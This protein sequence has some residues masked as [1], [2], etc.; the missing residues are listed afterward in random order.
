MS[1]IYNTQEDIATKIKS[2]LQSICQDIRKTQLNIIPYILIGMF[3]SESVVAHDIAKQLKGAF[4]LVQQP[5]VVKRIRR[6]FKNKLFDGYAF[7][8]KIIRYVIANYKKK[9]SDR[10][11]HVIFDHMFSHDNYTVFMIT[12]RIGKQGIPLWF[13][14]FEGNDCPDAFDENLLK[15]GITYVSELFGPG[16]DL[17]FLADRWFNSISLMQHIASLGHTFNLRLKKSLKVLVYDKK[18]GHNIWKTV[19]EL[20]SYQFHSNWYHDV[21]LSEYEYKVNIAISKR[22]GVAEPWII[23]TNG[24]AKQAIKDYSYRFGAIESVFKNQKSNG[25]YLENTVTA[26]LK[27]FESM[28]CIASVGVL[29]LTIF[30]ADFTKNTKLYKNVKIETHK[31]KGST[32]VR[33][34]SLFN[35]GLTLFHMAFNSLRYIHLPIRFILYDI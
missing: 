25:F 3:L 6:F 34:M 20:Q 12:M 5:S 16:Y 8:N 32:K 19:G 24:D 35:T 21:I 10:R 14:C 29:L 27:Y 28:Y 33:I 13:R 23:V 4:S 7:Y 30:G 22:E 2:I 26:S 9:H 15:L 18:E 11:V 17:V 31:I 1:K